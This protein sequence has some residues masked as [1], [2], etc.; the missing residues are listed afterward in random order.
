MKYYAGIGSR[1]TP[2]SLKET[3]KN[4]VLNLND[5]DYIL[6]SGGADGADLYFEEYTK[7][8]EIFLPWKGF[9]QNQSSLYDIS[10]EAL[11]LAKKYHPAWNNLSFAVQ[12]L[13]ARNVYQILGKDLKTPVDFVVCWTKNG[14]AIGGTSQAMRIAIDKN[15]PIYNL[16][17]KSDE[18][19]LNNLIDKLKMEK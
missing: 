1:E 7:N 13:M 3:I 12:K 8:K 17:N 2:V 14:K 18:N 6:R 4:I 19:S 10:N 11:G 9:N 5:L 16:Y 15:I